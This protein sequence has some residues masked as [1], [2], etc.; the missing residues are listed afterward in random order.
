MLLQYDYEYNISDKLKKICLKMIGISLNT[1]S[2][3]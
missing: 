1:I 2:K 3:R